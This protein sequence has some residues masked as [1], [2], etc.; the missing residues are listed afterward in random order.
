M[1]KMKNKTLSKTRKK[2]TLNNSFYEIITLI[3]KPDRNNTR[4]EITYQSH[5]QNERK[6]PK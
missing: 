3:T 6:I 2:G 5:P 4:K 1:F